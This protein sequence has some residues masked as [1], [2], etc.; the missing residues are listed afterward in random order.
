MFGISSRPDP[1]S[2][3]W[4]LL[5]WFMLTAAGTHPAA[6]GSPTLGI[7]FDPKQQATVLEWE[8]GPFPFEVSMSGDLETWKPWPGKPAGISPLIA[9]IETGDPHAFFRLDPAI[10]PGKVSGLVGGALHFGLSLHWEPDPLAKTYSL[11]IGEKPDTGPGSYLKAIHDLVANDYILEGFPT[12]AVYYIAVFGVNDKGT[13]PPSGSIRKAIARTG[14]V[15]G[16]MGVRMSDADGTPFTKILPSLFVR[17]LEQPGNFEVDGVKTGPDGRFEFVDVAP[18]DYRLAWDGDPLVYDG[19]LKDSF[20]VDRGL[21]PLGDIVADSRPGFISGRI[22][23]QGGLPAVFTDRIFGIDL[24]PTLLVHNV[25]GAPVAMVQVDGD[26][27]FAL[28]GLDPGEFPV[29]L[30]AEFRGTTAV[31][32]IP[33][34]QLAG[35][36]DLVFGLES[37]RVVSAVPTQDGVR[38]PI[39]DCGRPIRVETQ[40]DAPDQQT[41]SVRWAA[42]TPSGQMLGLA[43]GENPTFKFNLD[44][45]TVVHF[46]GLVEA[47]GALPTTIDFRVAA[48]CGVFGR[49]TG[50][51]GIWNELAPE[52]LAALEG[53]IVRAR[54]GSLLRSAVTDAAGNFELL[55]VPHLGPMVLTLE[56]PG[57]V[58]WSWRFE[59]RP[60]E[61]EYGMVPTEIMS[62]TIPAAGQP[63]A[64]LPIFGYGYVF[65]PACFTVN[66]TPYSGP[67]VIE[68]ALV[69]LGDGVIQPFPPNPMR[70]V[71]GGLVGALNPLNYLWLAVRGP[72]GEVLR[73]ISGPGAPR[74][75][76]YLPP[77][78]NLP[79]QLLRRDESQGLFVD[80]GITSGT[81]APNSPFVDFQYP[82]THAA[83]LWTTE[84]TAITS[85]SD[86]EISAD[87]SLNYPFDVL[88]NNSTFPVTVHGPGQ[89]DIGSLRLVVQQ[90]NTL[91][92]FRV[93][94]QRQAPGAFFA[95]LGGGSPRA[96][97]RKPVIINFPLVVTGGVPAITRTVRL[98]LGRTLPELTPAS[99][100]TGYSG[101]PAPTPS[102]RVESL[103]TENA[104]L[105]PYPAFVASGSPYHPHIAE[106]YYEAIRAPGTLGEWKARNGFPADPTSIPADGIYAT[107]FYYN[108]GDLGFARRLTM[109]KTVGPDGRP[110]IAMAV[111]NFRNLDEA[112]ND[113]APIATVCMEY[114]R[115]NVADG[116]RFVKFTAYDDVGALANE[117]SLDGGPAKPMPNLCVVCHGG[118]AF[119]PF[120]RNPN[121]GSSFLPFDLESYTYHSKV[122]TQKK[123][124]A[125]L[126]QGVLD[127]DPAPAIRELVAGWYGTDRPTTA[128]GTFHAGFVPDTWSAPAEAPALY[129]DTFRTSCRIC[130]ISRAETIQFDSYERFV[131][132]DGGIRRQVCLVSGGMPSTQRTWAIFWGGRAARRLQ[133]DSRQPATAVDYPAQVLGRAPLANL[134]DLLRRR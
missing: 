25:K 40:I 22:H 66:G 39:L 64:S 95:D 125:E 65:P 122:G 8:P 124:F 88:V 119:D 104:F 116:P 102:W 111:T 1:A 17:L 31:A 78:Q 128:P 84:S 21:H 60:T 69:R 118:R 86:I 49:F 115:R 85:Q 134:S 16:S 27:A 106:T 54:I 89:H 77:P 20:H 57:Y 79:R 32:K 105:A 73:P 50:R 80:G 12:D 126:N 68:H 29:T 10:P 56:K 53:V 58:P 9:V 87:R 37:P 30:T 71:P 112:R 127:T 63:T 130:H 82:L 5:L 133:V 100:T 48:S 91:P 108:L 33:S 62:A 59:G 131:Q 13:S 23:F 2:G 51:V 35:P 101:S 109:R 74:L 47:P 7:R 110:N 15:S 117:I 14:R 103:E 72:N 52:S 113:T 93:L 120:T 11:Y 34:P 76:F 67:V 70:E 83:G 98:G 19:A 94:D 4:A 132:F 123:L 97:F 114:S 99:A 75:W 55:A 45:E 6:A 61:K 92:R 26:G 43:D 107:A 44:R 18:G 41:V 121:L 36:V 90:A 129:H 46:H 42:L 81:R 3:R 38:V 96:A 28:A 24:R